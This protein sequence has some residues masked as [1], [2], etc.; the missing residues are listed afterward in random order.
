MSN[1]HREMEQL[2]VVGQ[3][4]HGKRVL[5]PGEE[6]VGSQGEKEDDA[7]SQRVLPGGAVS[8]LCGRG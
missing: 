2:L 1:T 3:G 7:G 5:G 6:E 8:A 4:Y